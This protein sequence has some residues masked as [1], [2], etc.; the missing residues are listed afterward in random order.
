[1]QNVSL[2]TFVRCN[3]WSCCWS[4]KCFCCSEERSADNSWRV[5]SKELREA[6]KPSSSTSNARLCSSSSAISASS[7]LFS[8]SN[9]LSSSKAAFSVSSASASSD[10]AAATSSALGIE[11]LL[12]CRDLRKDI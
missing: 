2:Y 12:D 4:C 6:Q 7:P 8:S 9:I 10:S 1:M 5:S 11:E 3:R